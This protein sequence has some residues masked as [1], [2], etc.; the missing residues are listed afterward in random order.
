MIRTSRSRF[1]I[2]GGIRI[3]CGIKRITV[4]ARPID[5]SFRE[6]KLLAFFIRQLSRVCSRDQLLNCVGSDEIHDE[7]CTVDV[8]DS[9]LRTVLKKNKGNPQYIP[10]V[11]G[12]GCKFR[13]SPSCEA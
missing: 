5:L 4:N 12:I 7:P 13:E 1:S 11:R 8:H 9:R 3:D 10:S 2:S 6:V